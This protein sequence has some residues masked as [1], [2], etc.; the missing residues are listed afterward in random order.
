M[1]GQLHGV[2]SRSAGVG[3]SPKEQGTGAQRVPQEVRDPSGARPRTGPTILQPGG[4]EWLRDIRLAYDSD[5][6]LRLGR[7]RKALTEMNGYWYKGNSLYVPEMAGARDKVLMDQLFHVFHRA[8]Q[9]G[10]P[11]ITKTLDGIAKC[12][13]WPSMRQDIEDY[14][15]SCD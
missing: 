7:K 11:G 8:L 4:E 1:L 3:L 15:S 13:W 6:Y 9:A 10:H 2:R 12:Y 5:A 14:V